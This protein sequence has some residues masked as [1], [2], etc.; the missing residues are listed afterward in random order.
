[1]LVDG[2]RAAVEMIERYLHEGQTHAVAI[3]VFFS[4]DHGLISRV[5]V[6]REGSADP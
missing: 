1:V 5:K 3:A 2:Q 4:F 6:F